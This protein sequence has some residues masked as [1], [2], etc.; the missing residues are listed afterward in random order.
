M[1]MKIFG[2]SRYMYLMSTPYAQGATR[3]SSIACSAMTC[4][5]SKTL[6]THSPNNGGVSHVRALEYL[7]IVIESNG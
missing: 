1:K 4:R 2:Q 3:K 6:W 5:H 7:K